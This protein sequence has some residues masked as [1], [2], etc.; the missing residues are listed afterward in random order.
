MRKTVRKTYQTVLHVLDY[1]IEFVNYFQTSIRETKLYQ[2]RKIDPSKPVVLLVYGFFASPR[3]F[4]IMEERLTQ[5]GFSVITLNF[6]GFL[7]VFNTKGI[8]GLAQYIRREMILT[9]KKHKFR[10]FSIVAHS[11]GGL[12]ARYYVKRL[13]GHKY[14][15]HLI[16]MATPHHGTPL[17]YFGFVPF[18]ALLAPSLLQMQPMS[19][20]IR[21]LKKGAWPITTKLYSLYSKVDR[22]AV[23]PSAILESKNNPHVFNIEVTGVR[24]MAF[25]WNKRAY[26]IIQE[27][28]EEMK[29]TSSTTS[30]TWDQQESSDKKSGS[31]DQQS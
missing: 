18:F 13:Q 5:A 7:N 6:G 4:R 3:T 16:T 19:R 12:I 20:F 21:N 9:M 14:V 11:K 25:P 29:T 22:V 31:G 8:I 24:H 23:Y 30:R 2:R 15:D 17:G 27:I 28:L 26:L 1:L 10:K